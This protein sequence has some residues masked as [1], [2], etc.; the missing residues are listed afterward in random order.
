MNAVEIMGESKDS[1]VSEGSTSDSP[2]RDPTLMIKLAG[3]VHGI[4]HTQLIYVAAKLGLADLLVDG[5]TSVEELA[6]ATKTIENRLYRIM[7]ALTSIGI[8]AESGPGHFQLTPLAELLRTDLPDSMRDFAIMMGSPWHAGAS[9]KH[10]SFCR[11]G[12][13]FLQGPAS[14]GA[15]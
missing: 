3:R 2:S 13:I 8:F 15:V 14:N 12:G 11:T 6:K 4:V 7:R 5:A 9:G 1:P 10:P